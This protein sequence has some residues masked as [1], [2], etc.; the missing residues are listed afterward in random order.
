MAFKLKQ[1][2]KG[3]ETKNRKMSDRIDPVMAKRNH[4]RRK[5]G[6]LYEIQI[7]GERDRQIQRR[8]GK[9]GVIRVGAYVRCRGEGSTYFNKMA[10]IPEGNAVLYL[11]TMD[12]FHAKVLF[13]DKIFAVRRYELGLEP[14]S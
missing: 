10:F 3:V 14:I 4:T 1:I 9:D 13:M 7:H 8:E 2:K 6:K 5:K 12:K 11:G